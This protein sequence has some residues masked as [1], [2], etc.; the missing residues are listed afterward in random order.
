MICLTDMRFCNATCGLS[1]ILHHFRK[2]LSNRVKRRDDP[3]RLFSVAL[4]K[5]IHALYP[6]SRGSYK[7]IVVIEISC[8]EGE[9]KGQL[10]RKDK[11]RLE[12]VISSWNGVLHLKHIQSDGLW[13]ETELTKI[14]EIF[15]I[16]NFML[17]LVEMFSPFRFEEK[18]SC[19][20]VGRSG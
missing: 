8:N 14:A 2:K 9:K 1:S 6:K 5:L 3:F 18:E 4:S 7:E 16:F 11:S 12:R 10:E 20:K 17:K 15:F 13:A 19:K